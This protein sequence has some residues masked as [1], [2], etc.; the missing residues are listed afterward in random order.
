MSDEF[1]EL[2][3]KV[4]SGTHTSDNLT[5]EE[6]ASAMGMILQQEATPAQIGAFLIAH[7]IKRPTP[8]ELAGM[9]DAYRELGPKLPAI[10]GPVVIFGNPYD[11]R[12]RTAPVTPIVSL[13]LAASGIPVILHGGDSM[14]TKYG[15]PLIKIWKGLGVNFSNLSLTKIE[16]LLKTTGIGFIYLPYHFPLAHYLTPYRDEIGKRPPIATLELIWPPYEGKAHLVAG[17]VHPPTE[18]RF[19]N[20]FKILGVED[21]TTVKGL[22]GSCDLACSRTAIIGLG[23]PEEEFGFKRLTLNPHDYDFAGKDVE[24]ES[25]QKLIEQLQAVIEGKSSDLMKAS[26]WN[27]GF[28]LWRFGVCANLSQGFAEAERLLTTG[29]VKAKL[30]ELQNAIASQSSLVSH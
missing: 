4:G 18:E 7:R 11:G 25:L 13:I 6:S 10:D 1:R 14:P 17:F 19:R 16:H 12:S 27:G 5:R 29:K 28:Y 22:E 3:K 15:I 21:F 26:I 9:L 8:T 24:L 23:N 20:T 30:T 2:L